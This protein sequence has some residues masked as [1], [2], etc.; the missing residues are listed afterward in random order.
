ME[1]K[2]KNTIK[3]KEPNS[4]EMPLVSE[5]QIFAS[6][7]HIKATNTARDMTY[8]YADKITYDLDSYYYLSEIVCRIR[9]HPVYLKIK[10]YALQLMVLDC[11]LCLKIITNMFHILLSMVH[12]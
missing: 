12:E 8:L 2:N 10:I 4:W 3:H 11:T 9:K 5:P 7:K 6:H 1:Y